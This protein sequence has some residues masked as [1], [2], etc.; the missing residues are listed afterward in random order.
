MSNSDAQTNITVSD[1]EVMSEAENYRN[2]MYHQIA[3]LSASESSEVGARGLATSLHL[4]LDRE[5]VLPVDKHLPCVEHL[6][7][8]LGHQLKVQ[9]RQVDIA[10]SDWTRH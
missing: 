10:G 6:Q 7:A 2:W 3:P 4:L 5:M 1:L 8:R 9:P